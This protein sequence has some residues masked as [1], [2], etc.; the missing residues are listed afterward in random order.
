MSSWEDRPTGQEEWNEFVIKTPGG[1]FL[2][3][4]EFGEFNKA[5]GRKIWRLSYRPDNL[6]G[7]CLLVKKITRFGSFLYSPGGPVLSDQQALASLINKVTQV[8]QEEKVNFVRFDPRVLSQDLASKLT[9]LGLEAVNNFTQP[10]CSQILDLTQELAAL[11]SG[12]SDSTRYNIGWV[13]RQG[14]RIKVS[15]KPNDIQI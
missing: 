15:D 2:Q 9:S 7:V 8:A 5:L 10:Q 3:S 4:W 14:V 12:L 1:S 11:R 6:G 13:A